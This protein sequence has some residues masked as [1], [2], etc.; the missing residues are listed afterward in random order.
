M[1][2]KVIVLLIFISI[3][4]V[5]SADA[6]VNAER[7]IKLKGGYVITIS[8]A[9]NILMSSRNFNITIEKTCLEKYITYR[10]CVEL[11]DNNMRFYTDEYLSLDSAVASAILDL[12]K[13]NLI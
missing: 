10:I 5:I 9:L 2:V 7:E 4:L 12:D 11:I 13:I 1:E 8:E 6:S 3:F